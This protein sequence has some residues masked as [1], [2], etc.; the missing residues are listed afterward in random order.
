MV[1]TLKFT[2]IAVARTHIKVFDMPD[3]RQG[4]G[5]SRTTRWM[6][7]MHMEQ[8]L[9]GNHIFLQRQSTGAIYRLLQRTPQASGR[10]LCLRHR[11]TAV[12]QGLCSDE[13]WADMVS[14]LHSGVRSITLIPVDVVVAA[15]TTLGPTKGSAALIEALGYECPPGWSDS[16][17]TSEDAQ[18]EADTTEDEGDRSDGDG[19][20]GAPSVVNTEEYDG[21]EHP[22]DESLGEQEDALAGSS[23][24]DV[25]THKRPRT[26]YTLVDVP[27]SLEREL[28]AFAKWRGQ[29]VNIRRD[30]GSVE[31]IT[32]ISNRS[33]AL[34]LLGWLHSE[35]NITPSL[36]GVFGSDSLGAAVQ[37]FVDYLVESGRTYSTVSSYLAAYIALTRFVHAVRL[38]RAAPGAA[39]STKPIDAMRR[40]HRQALQEARVERKFSSK[41]TA[42]LGWEG[43]QTARAKAVRVYERECERGDDVRTSLFDATLLS[44][45]T[46][47][48]PDRVGVA[49][50]LRLGV[51]LKQTA[52]GGFDLDLATRDAHKTAAI[53]GPT[54]T[55]V[56]ACVCIFL[57]AW[58]KLTGISTAS[59]PYVFAC[60]TD[61]SKPIT[62]KRWTRVVQAIFKRHAG[63]PL[64]PKDLRSSFVTFLTSS[65]NDDEVLKSAAFAMRHSTRQQSGRAYDK[66]RSE[67]LSAAAVQVATKYAARFTA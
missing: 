9:Y 64:S 65:A 29:R 13:E 59:Q 46:S 24:A 2:D 5:A 30:G 27:E 42:W 60:D 19:S 18:D 7:Q 23:S 63:V 61:H 32:V 47:V 39:V 62:S 38:A 3:R 17:S 35:R 36:V 53:F 4:N 26:A 1:S 45:L 54:I 57:T 14:H 12:T 37:A 48:P 31:S 25:H 11:S 55:S 22:A 58:I 44:W 56:P 21:S 43:V 28:E 10:S 51:T 33:D 67:R 52:G 34:R 16:E 40:A 8:V 50:Q 20:A 6:F 15:C 66:D 49:R 41:P